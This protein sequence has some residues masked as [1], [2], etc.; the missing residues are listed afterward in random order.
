MEKRGGLNSIFFQ[1]PESIPV[2][3]A[4]RKRKV[5][6]DKLKS[7]KFPVTLEQRK[8]LRGLA[9]EKRQIVRNE[10]VSNTL[11]FI[12]ALDH[13]KLYPDRL[14]QIEYQDT[15]Q[16]MHIKLDQKTFDYVEE[17]AFQSNS[18]IRRFVHRYIMNYLNCGQVVI[19]FA[20][21]EA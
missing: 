2:N 10:S 14:H 12:A 4:E 6:S 16:Y 21:Y 13:Y 11:V 20:E 17:L 9:K 8:K 19:R 15:G 1:E 3:E 5:R 7:I 18:S